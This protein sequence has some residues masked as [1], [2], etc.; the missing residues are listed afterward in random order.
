MKFEDIRSKVQG[1]PFITE[2]NARRL[3]DLIIES[4]PK[5]ILELGVAH[6]VATCYMAAALDELG[7]GEIT[8]VD[9]IETQKSFSPSPENLSR[10][11]GLE[12][13]IKI[14][15]MQS[16]YN[17]FLH[18]QIVTN[19]VNDTCMPLYDLCIIDGPK[20]WTIDGAAFFM[21]DKLLQHGAHL[22]FDDYN[23]T[24][25]EADSRR[26]ETDGISHRSMSD[27]ERSTPQIRDVFEY[28]VKQHPAY[29]SF[30]II[31]GADW[32]IAHK[33][34]KPEKTYSV[35]YRESFAA[36]LHRNVRR[37]LNKITK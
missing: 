8:A 14:V 34:T 18:D 24:Y 21:V 33:S 28:L 2:D 23:W 15:R 4:R 3:Y 31:E 10:Q 7:E 13:Y 11:V 26:S 1:I 29:G 27:D 17:W 25:A 19:T 30:Q 16:G 37:V 6:G 20:N 12:E 9:L 22:I 32:A 5:R 36:A 35:V